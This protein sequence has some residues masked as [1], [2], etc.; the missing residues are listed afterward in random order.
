MALTAK[1][2]ALGRMQRKTSN[3]VHEALE[4]GFPLGVAV[5]VCVC[6]CERERWGQGAEK[7]LQKLRLNP[8][9]QGC[10]EAHLKYM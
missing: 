2:Y 10:F 1:M 6:V 4:S 3:G 8:C 9:F 5:C 7:E